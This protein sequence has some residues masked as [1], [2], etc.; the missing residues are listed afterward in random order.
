[1]AGIDSHFPYTWTEKYETVEQFQAAYPQ[2]MFDLDLHRLVAYANI[3]NNVFHYMAV[4]LNKQR[5]LTAV[6]CLAEGSNHKKIVTGS[7]ESV[8]ITSRTEIYHK[9]STEFMCYKSMVTDPATQSCCNILPLL[10]ASQSSTLRSN[11][12]TPTIPVKLE[13]HFSDLNP[14]NNSD[15]SSNIDDRS[16]VNLLFND[17]TLPHAFTSI[18]TMQYICSL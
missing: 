4:E 7:G 14:A 11:A 3:M 9:E 8:Y 5:I 10:K 17:K 15:M 13:G 12:S 18:G 16:N 1:M 6:S 2:F